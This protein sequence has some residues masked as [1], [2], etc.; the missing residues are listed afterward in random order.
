MEIGWWGGG[1]PGDN[2]RRDDENDGD[3]EVTQDAGADVPAEQPPARPVARPADTVTANTAVKTVTPLIA[4]RSAPPAPPTPAAESPTEAPA[5]TPAE[6]DAALATVSYL[7]WAAPGIDVAA[8]S[9]IESTAFRRPFVAP[10]RGFDR[11]DDRAVV[12]EPG[13]WTAEY[14]DEVEEEAEAE[15]DPAALENALIK[16]LARRDLS[17]AEAEQFLEQNGLPAE[18]LEEWIER[19]ERLG[20]LDDMR[21]A[22][23]LV[24]QL[25]RRKGLGSSSIRQELGRRKINPIVISEALGES[26]QD[27]E[28]ARALELAVKRAGQLSSYDEATAER[29]LTGFLMRKGYPSGVVRDAVKAALAGR[30]RPSGGV[31]FR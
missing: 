27:E 13:D 15:F 18:Q 28:R 17:I 29:R 11:D 30:K 21:L 7:P 23:N 20:Y 14:S 26:D 6:R 10:E 24:D 3:A 2:D 8:S 9:G 19:I 12:A 25:R 5:D 1:A 31:R 4:L 16:K 22:E